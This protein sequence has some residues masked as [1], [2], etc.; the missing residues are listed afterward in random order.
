MRC[1][2][3]LVVVAWLACASVVGGDGRAPGDPR[4]AAGALYDPSDQ[5][6]MGVRFEP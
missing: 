1:A 2:G 6:F 3:K 5:V 4:A